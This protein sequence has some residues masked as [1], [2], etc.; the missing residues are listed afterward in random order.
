MMQSAPALALVC[1]EDGWLC[2]LNPNQ[3]AIIQ[4]ASESDS[5]ALALARLFCKTCCTSWGNKSPP[6]Y[7]ASS[8]Q[9][10]AVV[11]GCVAQITLPSGV[12]PMV[13]L[14]SPGMLPKATIVSASMNS[15]S[16]TACAD[17]PLEAAPPRPTEDLH[18]NPCRIVE[19]D[20]DPKP[21]FFDE[22]LGV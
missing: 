13:P 5:E 17:D 20:K 1:L 7:S 2:N 15:A 11:V 19:N 3:T 4:R 12:V 8:R 18:N 6:S 14:T 16:V 10:C 22:G 9:H 21:C